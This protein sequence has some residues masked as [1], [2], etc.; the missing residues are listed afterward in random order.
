MSHA[1]DADVSARLR[2]LADYPRSRLF[3]PRLPLAEHGRADREHRVNECE[4]Q[5]VVSV[6]TRGS[7]TRSRSA[8]TKCPVAA[9]DECDALCMGRTS[10]PVKG[11]RSGVA[12]PRR[13]EFA[14][15][16]TPNPPESASNRPGIRRMRGF[17]VTV[18][19][20][21]M[22]AQPSRSA[23]SRIARP[24]A[25]P[26]AQSSAARAS[27]G[28]WVAAQLASNR[29]ASSSGE[30]S[31]AVKTTSARPGSADSSMTS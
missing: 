6:A 20:S 12:E 19:P 5:V 15:A 14:L 16:A 30:P 9:I 8:S 22:I 27:A 4:L 23:D 10:V 3:G 18:R 17:V 1:A 7:S 2:R 31:S 25:R 26:V 13:H 29:S 28:S 11:L 21:L 24:A